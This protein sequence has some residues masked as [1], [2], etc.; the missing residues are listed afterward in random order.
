MQKRSTRA[1]C[2]RVSMVTNQRND[3]ISPPP[4]K[5][6]RVATDEA[7]KRPPTGSVADVAIDM[8]PK[9]ANK[10]HLAVFSWNINGIQ[11]FLPPTTAPTTSF[12][13]PAGQTQQHGDRRKQGV[14]E[15]PLRVFLQRHNWPEIVFLQEIRVSPSDR[16]TP[17]TL[18]ATVNTSLGAHDTPSSP[19]RYTVDVNRPRDKFNARG[20]GGKVHGVGTLIREDLARRNVSCVRHAGWDLEGRVTIVELGSET[21]TNSTLQQP[22]ATTASSLGPTVVYDPLALVN[23]YAVNGTTNPYRSPDT[24]QTTGT[25]HDHK[26]AFHRRLRNECLALESRGFHVVLAG[27]LNVARG[28]LDGWPHLRTFPRQHCWNRADFNALFFGSEDNARAEAYLAN[29]QDQ[30]TKPPRV[31]TPGTSDTIPSGP[32]SSFDG[33][34]IFR[35]V[36]RRTRKYTYHPRSGKE[37][38][39]SCDRVD[40]IIVSQGLYKTERVVATDILDL[41]QE[42]GTSDHVPLWA[43]IR[44]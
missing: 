30:E 19:N 37:W 29:P 23:V 16:K 33:V 9:L 40:L 32:S 4:L 18:L 3:D 26:L 5:R 25:R 8:E 17:A 2:S 38:G 1:D 10:R 41:P 14:F 43:R 36:H 24:G 21:S 27:D 15:N 11:P 22:L 44:Y 6:R 39:S 7:G 12:F 31:N 28:P 20:F 35:A 13:Q 42:R 34:D